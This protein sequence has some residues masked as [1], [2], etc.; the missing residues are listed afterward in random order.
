MRRFQLVP[1]GDHK[2]LYAFAQHVSQ[3][4]HIPL[5]EADTVHLD[6]IQILPGLSVTVHSLLKSV[7]EERLRWA[8][9]VG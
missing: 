5:L 8:T 9:W 7:C 4:Y 1:F 6:D 2:S 3:K